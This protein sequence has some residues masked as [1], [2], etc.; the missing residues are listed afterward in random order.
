MAM[1]EA[2][3]KKPKNE[4][5]PR[6]AMPEQD[7]GVRIRNFDEVPLG[8]SEELAQAEASRC[9]RCKKPSCIKGCPVGNQIP[10]FISLIRERDYL[11]AIAKIRE[12]NNLPAVCGRVCPQEVQ[13]EGHCRLGKVDEPVAIGRLERFVADYERSR[14]SRIVPRPESATGRRVA[15]V[16]AGPAGLTAAEDLAR[17]GHDV[18][19]FEAMTAGGG[20]L[21]YGIPEFCLPKAIVRAEIDYLMELGVRFEYS[22][23]IGKTLSAESLVREG[24][25]Q[26]VFLGMGAGVPGFMRISGEELGGV[27]SAN[28]Y[29][30]RANFMRADR[31]PEHETRVVRGRRVAVI[32]G[33]DVAV[34]AARLA[35][36][37][38]AEEVTI[39]YRRSEKEMP[40]RRDEIHH[41]RAEG[42]NILFLTTPVRYLAD[43]A[44]RVRAMECIRMALGECDASGRARPCPV[45]GSEF[46]LPVDVVVVA[47]GTVA[48]PLL[49]RLVPAMAVN[50]RG[51]V[52]A[53]PETGATSRPGF[54]A[55]GDVVTGPKTVAAAMAG[56]KRSALAMHAYLMHERGY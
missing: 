3:T 10:A 8:Y 1:P 14:G 2:T 27:L 33:G 51:L 21:A 19:V 37:L 52:I 24:R 9:L 29:L 55:A 31:H 39:V 7:V 16:G 47:I 23:L 38:G 45:A 12:T 17:A 49:A 6:Q 11:G 22:I 56:G 42:T 25:F 36:R 35:F 20:V 26:A 4:R 28:E 34:D 15:V 48:S 44:G 30:F 50:R 40:A 43:D 13:C 53:D 46:Q 54:Y 32:G 18:T 41:A 5:L